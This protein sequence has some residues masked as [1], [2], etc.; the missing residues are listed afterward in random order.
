MKNS[1]N[2]K[3]VV[4]IIGFITLLAGV[5]TAISAKT[6]ATNFFPIY[7]GL[8]LIGTALSHKEGECKSVNS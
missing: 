6:I 1:N 8:A 7:T 5:F 3:Q 4:F 2:I